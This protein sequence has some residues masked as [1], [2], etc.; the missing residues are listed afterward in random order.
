MSMDLSDICC[1]QRIAI[2][3]EDAQW[4]DIPLTAE[5]VT[6]TEAHKSY[7]FNPEIRRF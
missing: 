3:I 4:D 1:N 6:K 2:L 7:Q 5:Y